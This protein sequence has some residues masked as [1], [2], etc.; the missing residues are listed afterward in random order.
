MEET[1]NR[2]E[3]AR[4]VVEFIAMAFAYLIGIFLT[5]QSRLINHFSKILIKCGFQ[6]QIGLI[7]G[8][9][10]IAEKKSEKPARLCFWATQQIINSV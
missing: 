10:Y 7:N 9:D 3:I 8:F 2:F 4:F 5:R 1:R 6:Y